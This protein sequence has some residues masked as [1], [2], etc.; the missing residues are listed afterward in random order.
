MMRFPSSRHSFLD[1]FGGPKEAK[2]NQKSSLELVENE[3]SEKLVFLYPSPAKSLFLASYE[4]QDRAPMRA[5]SDFY[6]N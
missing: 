2:I 5:M 4:G 3:K 1:P 6:S